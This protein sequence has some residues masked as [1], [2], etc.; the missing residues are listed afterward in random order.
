MM[1][2]ITVIGELENARFETKPRKHGED[3]VVCRLDGPRGTYEI[4]TSEETADILEWAAEKMRE[5]DD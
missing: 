5:H 4:A 3:E 1:G 2:H